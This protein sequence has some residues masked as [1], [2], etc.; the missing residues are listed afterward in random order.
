MIPAPVPREPAHDR[1]SSRT[2]PLSRTEFP[3]GFAWGC[4]TSA[5]QTEGGAA[6][7]GRGRR[8]G[9][10]SASRPAPFA[11]VQ[12]VRWPAIAMTS[13]RRISISRAN[14]AST[15]TVF[16]SLGRASFRSAAARVR[17]GKGLDFYERLI[18]GMLARR[19][20]PWPTLY[21]WDLPQALQ[22]GGGWARRDTVTA[23]ARYVDVISRHLGDR[24]KHWITHNEPWCSA[25]I[26][27]YEGVHAPGLRD[28]GTAAGG[29]TTFCC[30]MERPLRPSAAM[31]P[32][33]RWALR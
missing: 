10:T 11:T 14:S 20:K 32:A 29:P 8:Y 12:R 2:T 25:F 9:I 5:Y 18:D 4:A 1:L 26:G 31:S 17:T 19:I 22:A 33:H 3:P 27:H 16:P 21:R 30:R 7:G 15:P 6:D 13:G 23:F 24:V 28:L